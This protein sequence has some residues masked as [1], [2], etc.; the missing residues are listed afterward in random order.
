MYSEFQTSQFEF[1][2]SDAFMKLS[3]LIYA[4]IISGAAAEEFFPLKL[5]LNADR[6]SKRSC[7]DCYDAQDIQL[8]HCPADLVYDTDKRIELL[9]CLCDLPIEYYEKLIDCMTDCESV[10]LL[11]STTLDP[12]DLKWTYCD[13]AKQIKTYTGDLA[14]YTYS[15]E[16]ENHTSVSQEENHTSV[17][18]EENHTSVPQE[19]NNTL[20]QGPTTNVSNKT[21]TASTT[22][23]TNSAATFGV[24]SI[25]ALFA[26]SML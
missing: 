26:L 3:T 15:P 6:L 16:E 22:S 1:R 11:E 18:Q 17:S 24:A 2:Q 20:V 9:D 14:D 23:S 7:S 19:E 10:V 8:D 13:G 12:E 25:L 21:T 4:S 5:F